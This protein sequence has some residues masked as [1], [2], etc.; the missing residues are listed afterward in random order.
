MSTVSMIISWIV[1]AAGGS[2]ALVA[3]FK[4]GPE[5]RKISADVTQAGV[6]ATKVLTETALAVLQPSVDQIEFLRTE[7]AAARSEI[8]ELRN[9]LA[10]MRRGNERADQQLRK[11]I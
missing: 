10:A 1:G 6:N 7:L 9:E 4:I 11:E 3:L 8:T 2:A 5:R